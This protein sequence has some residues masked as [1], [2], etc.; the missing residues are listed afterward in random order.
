MAKRNGFF[1]RIGEPV[2]LTVGRSNQV[3]KTGDVI[4]AD[5]DNMMEKQG[6]QFVPRFDPVKA[7]ME[8]QKVD[9]NARVVPPA[10]NNSNQ[11]INI[12]GMQ[13]RE[14]TV[15]PRT[16]SASELM[17]DKRIEELLESKVVKLSSI[18]EVDERALKKEEK[19]V[20]VNFDALKELKK[21]SNKDWFGIS[22]EKCKE[23]LDAAHIDYSH[24]PSEKWELVK[25]IKSVIKDIE[26]E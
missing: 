3:V 10:Q 15:Q 23:V 6:W 21:Y 19:E 1:K 9:P 11:M 4:L 14:M 2:I 25:F 5:F 13:R 16:K 20:V 12:N 17:I 22:K 18:G 7:K 26:V 8:V 24:V